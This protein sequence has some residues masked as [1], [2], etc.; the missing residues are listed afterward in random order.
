MLGVAY[1]FGPTP[2]REALERFAGLVEAAPG[3]R[4][5]FEGRTAVLLAMAGRL[6]DARGQIE[7]S[8]DFFLEM[9]RPAWAAA[10]L[11]ARGIVELLA[12]DALAAERALRQG[13]EEFLQLD[14]KAV[15]STLSASLAQAL[16]L[17]GR[18]EEA[19]A[20]IDEARDLGSSDD[21]ATEVY[22]RIAES[23][24]L[25]DQGDLHAAE[26]LAREAVELADGGDA[27]DDQGDTRSALARVLEASGRT[28]EAAAV[29]REAIE[30][31]ER[32]GNVVSAAR[33]RER[34]TT[35]EG[36]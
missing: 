30:R 36:A 16:C 14:E 21:V 2:A 13:R 28:E 33:A 19:S 7:R 4:T 18:F 26:R 29:V 23:M 20:F 10:N 31:Y 12:G 5:E 25:S 17:Q 24:V 15:L 34:L 6:D 3:R 1:T 32:K 8:R 11:L 22:W 27:L 35:L 9:G